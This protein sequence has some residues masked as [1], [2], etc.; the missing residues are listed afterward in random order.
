[1]V[2]ERVVKKCTIQIGTLCTGLSHTRI[3][4]ELL[5]NITKVRVTETKYL[6]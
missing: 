6:L 3:D 1:M 4:T 5:E 2:K